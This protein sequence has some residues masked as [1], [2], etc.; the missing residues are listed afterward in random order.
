MDFSSVPILINC[1]LKELEST[2]EKRKKP[3]IVSILR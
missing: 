2:E 3:M 1:N